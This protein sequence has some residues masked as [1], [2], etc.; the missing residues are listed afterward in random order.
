MYI[1]ITML[2]VPGT[3]FDP[4]YNFPINLS[5]YSKPGTHANMNSWYKIL[6]EKYQYQCC[7]SSLFSLQLVSVSFIFYFTSMAMNIRHKTFSQKKFTKFF[8]PVMEKVLC[9][10]HYERSGWPQEL[11]HWQ[12][13]LHCWQIP[14]GFRYSRWRTLPHHQVEVI[15]QLTWSAKDNHNPWKQIHIL[16]FMHW[17]VFMIY[18]SYFRHRCMETRHN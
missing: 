8:V 10:P 12:P 5:N 16:L 4:K 9:N 11:L 15:C 7:D 18:L 3:I 17:R 6:K 2:S 1:N 14:S 13:L